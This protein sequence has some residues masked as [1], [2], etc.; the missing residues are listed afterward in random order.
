MQTTQETGP[1]AVLVDIHA[2]ELRFPF[3]PNELMTCPTYLKNITDHHVAFRLQLGSQAK[4]YY[5]DWLCG[6]I[7]PGSTYTLNVT[8]KERKKPPPSHEDK[9]L[10]IQSTVISHEELHTITE[11]KGDIDN[12]NF[13]TKVQE[14]GIGKVHEQ[15]LTAVCDKHGSTKTKVSSLK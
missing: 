3:R 6:N 9:L 11:G 2:L 14:K 10:I 13:F 1:C 4:R 15:K 12:V 8:M 7:L 5:H